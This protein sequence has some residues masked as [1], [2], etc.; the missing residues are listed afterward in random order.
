MSL[1]CHFYSIILEG[2]TT[3][4]TDVDVDLPCVWAEIWQCK[5]S[6]HPT[7]SPVVGGGCMHM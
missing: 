4:H 1:L 2:G 7:N 3:Q 5:T 6:K